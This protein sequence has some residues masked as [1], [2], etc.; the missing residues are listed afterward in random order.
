MTKECISLIFHLNIRGKKENNKSLRKET[1]NT[2]LNC[3]HNILKTE[4]TLTFLQ[5]RTSIVHHTGHIGS[6][7]SG[8]MPHH[9]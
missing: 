3:A 2:T 6:D 4:A 9:G 5:E 7:N 8:L 1:K